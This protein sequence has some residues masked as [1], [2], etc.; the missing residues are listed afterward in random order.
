MVVSSDLEGEEFLALNGGPQFKFAPPLSLLMNGDS[1]A[2]V[3][4]FWEKRSARGRKS[5][6]GWRE[7]KYGLPWHIVPAAFRATDEHARSRNG[8]RV[9]RAML[10]MDKLDPETL[11][12]PGGPWI[13][14]RGP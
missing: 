9:M 12:R 2:E 8:H 7:G 11:Q 4:K 5:G 3:D 10:K 6:C 13:V 1:Q 14:S